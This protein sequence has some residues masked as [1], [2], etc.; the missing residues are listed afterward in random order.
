MN[1][2]V[3]YDIVTTTRPRPHLPENWKLSVLLKTSDSQ[4]WRAL[5]PGLAYSPD[6]TQNYFQADKINHKPY[7]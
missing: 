4:L 3:H 1:F 7:S 5:P 2:S 6:N